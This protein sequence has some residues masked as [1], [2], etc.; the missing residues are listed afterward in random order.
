MRARLGGLWQHDDFVRLWAGQTISVFGSLITGTA[1]PFTAILALHATPFQV[2]VL[3][4]MR[5]V[6]GLVVGFA[7]GVWVDRARRR[8]V[9]IAA[10][11]GRA[12]LLLSVPAAY[13]FDA[14]QIEQLYVVAFVA[15]VLTMFFDVAYQSYLP[16]L[17]TDEELVEGNSKLTA[18][19]AVAEVGAFSVAGVLV[20]ALSGPVA[21]LIDAV[22]F[23]V[24]ALFVRSIRTPEPPPTR[25][26]E[27]ASAASEAAAGF[28]VVARDP[29]LRPL[30][31]ATALHSLS[32]GLFGALVLLFTTR[33]LGFEPGVLGVIF[34]VGGISSL[35]GALL[36][37]RA[38]SRLG[39]G[40]A[41]VIGLLMMGISM[42]FV[43][44][45]RG[46]TVAAGALLVSQQ[47]AGDG[48]Y[49]VYEIN[50]VSLRQS[51]TAPNVIGRV[52]AFMRMLTLGFTLVGTLM[53]GALAE[54]TG[55]RAT[56]AVGGAFTIAGA[57]VLFV[58]PLRSLRASPGPPPAAP[59][60]L[61]EAREPSRR[62]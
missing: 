14:L 17:V 4:S 13:A 40:P 19:S 24:S 42:L 6:P 49:T 44:L 11:A 3:A 10:D 48:C 59:I 53:A 52:N 8:P 28:R 47:L 9:M 45:A 46:A 22:T 57:G 32:F 54:T 1:L 35:L 61:L 37:A 7:A 60:A 51:I 26:R 39:V 29:L 31:A 15:G 50:E 30:A 18:T 38:G 21:I 56:L 16:S 34:A 12:L 41:M 58:S 62:G 25:A 55:L 20:Q 33:T 23:I 27:S 36:A 5:I 2:A 43:P